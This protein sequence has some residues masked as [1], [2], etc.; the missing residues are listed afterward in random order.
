MRECGSACTHPEHNARL[1]P[2]ELEVWPAVRQRDRE[3]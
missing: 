1:D 2:R 3:R